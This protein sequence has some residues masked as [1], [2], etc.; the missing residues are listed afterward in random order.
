[1]FFYPQFDP[2]AVHL[3]SLKIHWYGIMYLLAFWGCYALGCRRARESFRGW[4][5][6]GVS[7]LL[8]YV[9]LGVIVGGRV[10]YVLFYAFPA[11]IHEPLMLFKI[12]QGGMSFHG[13]LLGVC[14]AMVLFA[15]RYGRTFASVADFVAPL[16]PIGLMAGRVGNFINGELWGR[17]TTMPWGMVFPA[18]DPWPRHPSQLYAVFTEG[19]LLFVI[20][21]WY[22]AKPR[23]PWTTA[24]LFLMVYG[25]IRFIEEFFRQ[26]DLQIGF[27]AWDWLTMGQ[28]LSL[29]MVIVGL[30]VFSIGY[31]KEGC[32]AAVS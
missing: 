25:V 16:V 14:L 3:G 32:D 27:V 21:W 23:P 8:L 22:S 24:S 11:F 18:V 20:V 19:I 2:V 4:D 26:P 12:W 9:A 17:V 29:P 6:Q 13:G 10:G 28:L 31:R 30:I 15:R 1:M 7:D 5:S